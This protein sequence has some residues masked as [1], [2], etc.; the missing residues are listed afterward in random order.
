MGGYFGEFTQAWVRGLLLLLMLV[1][2]VIWRGWWRPIKKH[3]LG[4]FLVIALAGGLN[5]AP[6]FYAFQHIS[7]GTATVLFYAGLT[8]A[9]YLVGWRLFAEKI[10][11]E[12][13]VAL[14][15]ALLGVSLLFGFELQPTQILSGLA[16]LVAGVMGGVEV[17]VTKKISDNYHSLQIL[18]VLFLVMVVGN[19]ALALVMGES[20]NQAV[21]TG[22][23]LTP[24]LA[25]VAYAT[26]LLAAMWFVVI[27]FQRLEA[28]LASIVGLSEV[29]FAALFGWLVFSEGLGSWQLIGGL[30]V[31]L[32]AGLPTLVQSRTE[33]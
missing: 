23:L 3:D 10:G 6:Y 9:G 26:A 24:W 31:V 22:Q 2:L 17:S 1:P 29:V 13:M 15:L 27:G 16:A 12:R 8:V 32:A 4:W 28:S 33:R 11:V 7:V 19:G 30:L 25:L 5:Q 21:W 18:V 20:L 14:G